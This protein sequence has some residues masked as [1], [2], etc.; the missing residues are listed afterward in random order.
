[1][2]QDEDEPV[3]EDVKDDE[4]EDDD[5]DND[6]DDEDDDD[7]K[8]DGAQ[9][10][11]FYFILFFYILGFLFLFWMFLHSCESLYLFTW[12]YCI[13]FSEWISSSVILYVIRLEEFDFGLTGWFW[14]LG[15]IIMCKPI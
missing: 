8:D 4:E 5:H 1:M 12:F 2:L 9:G 14:K 15:C 13:S 3:V 11:L 7:N 10:C 6:D